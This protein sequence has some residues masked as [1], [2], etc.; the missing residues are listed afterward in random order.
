MHTFVYI[1]CTYRNMSVVLCKAVPTS[2]LVHIYNSVCLILP[3]RYCVITDVALER[4]KVTIN[5]GLTVCHCAAV[6]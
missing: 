5:E 4:K 6:F 3:H 2:C 1:L